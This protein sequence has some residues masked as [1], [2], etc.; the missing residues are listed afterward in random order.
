MNHFDANLP[1]SKDAN[2]LAHMST[3]IILKQFPEERSD[4][5]CT[6]FLFDWEWRYFFKSDSIWYD[7]VK[8]Y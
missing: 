7:I 6:V 3:V 4:H 2:D 1:A 8:I 5:Y